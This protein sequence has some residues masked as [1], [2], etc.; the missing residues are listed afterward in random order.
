MIIKKFTITTFF[1]NVALFLFIV[2]AFQRIKPTGVF[3][4]ILSRTSN[5]TLFVYLIHAFFLWIMMYGQWLWDTGIPAAVL[6]LIYT[7]VTYVLGV[8][9]SVPVQAIP[10][11]RMRDG[12]WRAIRSGASEKRRW[13]RV[14]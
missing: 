4:K 13:R 12:V 10:W 8:L 6:A 14:A 11:K 5:S 2:T 3:K 7:V 9:L 1:K